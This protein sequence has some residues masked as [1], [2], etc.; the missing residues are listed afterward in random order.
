MLGK[1]GNFNDG[2]VLLRAANLHNDE[3]HSFAS[4][5]IALKFIALSVS[6]SVPI[7]IVT[8]SKILET[9]DD[10]ALLLGKLFYLWGTIQKAHLYHTSL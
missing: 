7:V 10:S 2:P 4:F 6:G 3:F 1:A 8:A 9:N 5:T